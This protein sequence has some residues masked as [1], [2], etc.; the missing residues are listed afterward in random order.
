MVFTGTIEIFTRLHDYVY[1]ERCLYS[2]ACKVV[3]G[4]LLWAMKHSKSKGP[5]SRPR[6]ARTNQPI[7]TKLNT[8]DQLVHTINLVNVDLDR[9][10][11]VVWPTRWNKRLWF[12][13]FF[14]P[15]N[16]TSTR[17][18]GAIFVFDTSKDVFQCVF[19]HR[20]NGIFPNPILG[21][22]LFTKPQF[23]QNRDCLQ[24]TR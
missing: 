19:V 10:R 8:F 17:N 1:D 21:G 23:S 15:S 12:L 14:S 11:G 9:M 4:K 18:Y 13:T 16:L 3:Q 2:H 24:P 7:N 22:Q 6:T 5:F 20:Y